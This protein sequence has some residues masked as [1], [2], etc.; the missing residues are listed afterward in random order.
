MSV[1]SKQKQDLADHITQKLPE[2]V[3]YTGIEVGDTNAYTILPDNG[4]KFS[5]GVGSPLVNNGTRAEFSVNLP[6]EEGDSTICEYLLEV[7]STTVLSDSWHILGQWHDQPNFDLGESWD[8]HPANN[9]PISLHLVKDSNGN[10][11]LKVHNTLNRKS[12]TSKVLTIE[13]DKTY[14]I[15]FET[16]WSQDYFKAVNVTKIDEV[17]VDRTVRKNML[18]AYH[19][20]FKL[21]QYRDAADEALPSHINFKLLRYEVIPQSSDTYIIKEEDPF[22]WLDFDCSKWPVWEDM[23]PPVS[24]DFSTSYSEDYS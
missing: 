24:G 16:V 5:L 2:L 19:N 23:P 9:P 6:F 7:E 10:P 4:V 3:Q 17:V 8:T 12:S 15:T 21:G 20:Y 18:N 14:R 11:A 13:F 22:N 1:T